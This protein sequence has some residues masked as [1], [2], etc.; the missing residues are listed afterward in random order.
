MGTCR[1]FFF[2]L[3]P[4]R[5]KGRLVVNPEKIEIIVQK[6]LS[7]S[8]TIKEIIALPRYSYFLAKIEDLH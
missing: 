7:Y 2:I 3:Y 4:I 1:K 6:I 5:P 8:P